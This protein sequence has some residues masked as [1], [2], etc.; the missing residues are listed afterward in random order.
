MQVLGYI[1]LC[2]G[3]LVTTPAPDMSLCCSRRVQEE[4]TGR[5]GPPASLNC[6][7]NDLTSFTGRVLAYSRAKDRLFIRVRTDEQTTEN[8]T[9]RY[10]RKDE[11]A[12][13]FLLR[14][15]PFKAEDWQL[16]ETARG[17]LR[18]G[19]RATVWV[20]NDNPQPVVDWQPQERQQ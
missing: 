13:W 7:R 3:L 9:L 1:L 19:M 12:K 8:F 2:A 11:L 14:A 15:E 18:V 5:I 16:I 6:S 4:R 17:R 10:R 20:C